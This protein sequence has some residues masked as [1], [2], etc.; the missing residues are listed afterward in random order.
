MKPKQNP[1][2]VRYIA[3]SHV[4]QLVA[5]RR[6]SLEVA[7]SRSLLSAFTVHTRPDVRG[8]LTELARERLGDGYVTTGSSGS[9]LDWYQDIMRHRMVLCP[10]G[11]GLD[12]HRTWEALYLGRVP[13]VKASEMDATFERLPVIV[14]NDWADLSEERLEADYQAIMGRMESDYYDSAR[15]S[16]SHYACR[17]YLK[18]ERGWERG[19]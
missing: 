12:T 6:T 13:V 4:D 16:L 14:L 17:I 19:C 1:N 7:P 3:E 18:A 11:N 5:A 15:I 9:E 8:P 2:H 10:R